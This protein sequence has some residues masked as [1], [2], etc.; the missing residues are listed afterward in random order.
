MASL[1]GS[2][3]VK[4]RQA[5]KKCLKF[6]KGKVRLLYLGRNNPGYQCRLEVDLLESG[7]VEKDLRVLVD[8][9]LSMSQ[10]CVLVAKM[11]NGIL[12]CIRKSI[13]SKSREVIPPFCSALVRSHLECCVQVWPPQHK[14]D[15]ELLERVQ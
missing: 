14:G 15:M 11:G 3:V 7:S 8:N 5:E 12:G 9:A 2:K 1:A 10:Q 4:H 13:A 6:N